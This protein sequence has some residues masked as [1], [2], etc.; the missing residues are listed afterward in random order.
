MS[1]P[2]NCINLTDLVKRLEIDLGTPTLQN[3]SFSTPP[4]LRGLTHAHQKASPLERLS[5]IQDVLT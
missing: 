5:L 1:T 4:K 2:V 3:K